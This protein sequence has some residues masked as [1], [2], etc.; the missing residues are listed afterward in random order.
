MS[1]TSDRE[2]IEAVAGE[3]SAGIHR[4]L[5]FWVHQVEGVLDDTKL[6]TLGR[7]QALRVLVDGYRQGSV[8]ASEHAYGKSA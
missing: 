7:L 6:T 8:P 5:Q 2:F 1:N 4:A 3:M